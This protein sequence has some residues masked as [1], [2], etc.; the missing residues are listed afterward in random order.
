MSQVP[1]PKS[2]PSRSTSWKGSVS[3]AWL[4]TGTTSVWPDSP[5]PP[6]SP[7]PMVAN[8]LAFCPSEVGTRRLS[9][10]CSARYVSTKAM[11]GMLVLELVVS[12]AT[13]RA[14]SSFAVLS[15]GAVLELGLMRSYSGASVE[16]ALGVRAVEREGRDV[17]V[18][19]LAVFRRHAVAADHDARRRLQGTARRIAERFPGLENRH[20]AD[21]A[22]SPHLLVVPVAVGN[23]P[24]ARAQLHRLAA[25]VADLDGVGPEEPPIVGGRFL[26]QVLRRGA[27]ANATGDGFVHRRAFGRAW[28]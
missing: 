3:Q 16:A 6:P 21:H 17:N 7:G 24:V 12:K 8:R 20:V 14:S 1:R 23:A 13:S 5:M 25:L 28:R 27:H 15:V 19:L 4:A 26:L 11:S 22:R 2:L 10:P 18:E 9:M